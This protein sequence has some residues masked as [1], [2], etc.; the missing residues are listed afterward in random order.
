MTRTHFLHAYAA[1]LRTRYAWARDDDSKLTRFLASVEAT[2]AALPSNTA[3]GWQFDGP[4]TRAAWRAIG[5]T[6]KL[7]LKRLRALPTTSED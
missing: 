4:A 3:C 6:D 2:V 5:C 7:T 1:E